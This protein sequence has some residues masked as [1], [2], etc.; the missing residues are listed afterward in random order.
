MPEADLMMDKTHLFSYYSRK[1]AVI[2]KQVPEMKA[3]YINLSE[4]AFH[5]FREHTHP[6]WELLLIVEGT[7]IERID[8]RD[9]ACGKG[10]I[11]CIPPGVPHSSR[12][13]EGIRDFSVG[14]LDFVPVKSGGLIILQDD[15]DGNVY[16]LL[17]MLLESVRRKP[18]NERQ[19]QDALCQALYQMLVTLSKEELE[20]NR[21]V[22][23]LKTV[24]M[25]HLSDPG[26]MLGEAMDEMGFSRGYLRRVFLKETNETPLKWL[27]RLRIEYAKQNFRQYPGLYTVREIGE[28][29]GISDP[30]YFSRL[31]KRIE[32]I[33][34]QAY[35]DRVK[36]EHPGREQKAEDAPVRWTGAD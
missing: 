5:A 14:L 19:L 15:E 9:Y 12:S 6:S 25:N 8:G 11:F 24:M 31:F 23:E 17:R 7:G 29:A 33:S 27:N 34:P 13:E 18:P 35:I 16:H 2:E 28:M 26:F 10:D 22:R 1:D 32:G 3:D 30:Y 36:E 21:A 20:S 4:K